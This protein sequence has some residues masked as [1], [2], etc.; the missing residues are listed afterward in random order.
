MKKERKEKA[1]A[2]LLDAKSFH[3]FIS[4]FYLVISQ[5][6]FFVLY[7]FVF[8]SLNPSFL[9]FL[10]LDP[11]DEKFLLIKNHFLKQWKNGSR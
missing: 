4:F 8:S 9:A 6:F 1:I 3:Y 10:A 11:F 2:K 5:F 7:L